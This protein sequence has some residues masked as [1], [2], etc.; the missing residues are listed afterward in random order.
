MDLIL[1]GTR[2]TTNKQIRAYLDFVSLREE[3]AEIKKQKEDEINYVIANTKED[4]IC[5]ICYV[6]SENG[7]LKGIIWTHNNILSQCHYLHEIY[8]FKSKDRY[9]HFT[10]Y[11]V[12]IERIFAL[13]LSILYRYKIYIVPIESMKNDVVELFEILEKV[14]PTI[15]VE[16]PRGF[17]KILNK[18][19]RERK[20]YSPMNWIGKKAQQQGIIY[21]SKGRHKKRVQILHLFLH[22]KLKKV[23]LQHLRV[24]LNSITPI[25]QSLLEE[26]YKFGIH[27]H[28]GFCLA[29]TTG[30]VTIN[31]K[32]QMIPNSLGTVINKDIQIQINEEK[33][34]VVSGPIIAN[35]YVNT[36]LNH[37][38]TSNEYTTQFCGELEEFNSKQYLFITKKYSEF[39]LTNGGEYV[40]QIPIEEKLN[41]IPSIKGSIVIGENKKFISCLLF[42]DSFSVENELKKKAPRP[43]NISKDPFY[44]LYLKSQIENLNM[45]LPRGQKIKKFVV[46]DVNDSIPIL[47]PQSRLELIEKYDRQINLIYEQN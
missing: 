7:G 12:F 8:Q 5:E 17:E 1:L 22:K 37:D 23:G 21:E 10:S 11:S 40:Y 47:T 25:K 45:L 9:V 16:T 43:E 34:I 3:T 14:K 24:I 27:V 26:L 31:R 15:L 39:I 18:M 46:I 6:P 38:F 4:S 41:K 33:Q 19:G 44:G 35:G 42:T 30:F 32:K 36:T 13:Y 2:T 20:R 28:D 29:E